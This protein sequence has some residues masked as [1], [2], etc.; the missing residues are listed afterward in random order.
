[1]RDTFI[2]VTCASIKILSPPDYINVAHR[3]RCYKPNREKKFRARYKRNCVEL[4]G[5]T[6]KLDNEFSS[7]STF[8]SYR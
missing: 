8:Y 6:I 7:A 1:M 2:M 3:R 5:V 4:L